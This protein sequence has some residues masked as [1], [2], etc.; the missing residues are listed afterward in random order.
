MGLILAT[1][2]GTVALARLLGG[3]FSELEHLPVR[4]WPLLA[5]ML[6]SLWLGAGAPSA[7]LPAAMHWLGLL[8]AASCALLYCVRNRAVHGMGLVGAG[9]LLN[10]VV[11][12]VNGGMPVSAVASARV[13]VSH[14]AAVA[15]HQH[16]PAGPGTSLS[17]LGDVIPVPLPLR[18]EVASV[19]DVLVAAGLVQLLATGMFRPAG[20]RPRTTLGARTTLDAGSGR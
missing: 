14:A 8:A 7:G 2:V 1:L 18:P 9:L 17:W 3:R 4:G 19:G 20:R 10:A 13:G 11:I 6:G 12:G 5:G 16:V 15:D